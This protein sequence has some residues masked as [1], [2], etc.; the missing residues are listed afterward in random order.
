MTKDVTREYRD[1][2]RKDLYAF[3]E[4]TFRELNPQTP[5]LRN[6]HI[7]VLAAAL[8]RVAPAIFAAS[9]SM[10]RR[11]ASNRMVPRSPSRPG[12]SGTIPRRRSWP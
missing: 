11:A 2:I 6:W 9:S 3:I 12:S 10:S 1:L 8:E 7:E 4:L 5:F